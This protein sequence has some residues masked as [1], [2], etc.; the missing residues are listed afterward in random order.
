MIETS[1]L[2]VVLMK[3]ALI[4]PLYLSVSWVLTISY[5]LLTD[6]AVKTVA[7]NI[8]LLWPKC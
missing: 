3:A 8:A 2:K 5:Q 6:T 7:G 4:T 1:K